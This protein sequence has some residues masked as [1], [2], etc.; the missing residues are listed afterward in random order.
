MPKTDDR[1]QLK[2]K[3]INERI[4]GSRTGP[5]EL[6]FHSHI[7]KHQTLPFKIAVEHFNIFTQTEEV[8]KSNATGKCAHPWEKTQGKSQCQKV[9]FV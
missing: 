6:I 1:G 5:F 4:L 3:L 8:V 9:K 2:P 7:E